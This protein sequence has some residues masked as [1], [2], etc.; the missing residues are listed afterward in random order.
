MHK[1]VL[2]TQMTSLEDG[3]DTLITIHQNYKLVFKVLCL[4]LLI[5]L[6]NKGKY[7]DIIS[8]KFKENYSLKCLG[9]IKNEEHII[10]RFMSV[11]V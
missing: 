10:S 9:Q 8:F 3:Y 2:L 7:F 11:F 6:Q 1:K 4:I 5:I